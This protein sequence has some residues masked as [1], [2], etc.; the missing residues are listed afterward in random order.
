VASFYPENK[1]LL[2]HYPRFL[3]LASETGGISTHTTVQQLIFRIA[4]FLSHG[5]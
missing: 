2:T 5:T 4:E 3:P 1:N